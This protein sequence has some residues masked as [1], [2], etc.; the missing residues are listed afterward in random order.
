MA[1]KGSTFGAW[2]D[3]T[4]SNKRIMSRTLAES[5][6]VHDSAV[7]RW[8][9]GAGL[10]TAEA[11]QGIARVLD[12]DPLRLMVTAGLVP[13]RVAGVKP[14]PAPEPTARRERVRKQLGKVKG[15]T[16]KERSALLEA[17]EDIAMGDEKK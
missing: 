13:E 11:V 3:A 10:P 14:L 2:L 16:D 1:T 15:L 17:Y 7:S 12:V 6:G 4:L 8:R 5:V 9:A